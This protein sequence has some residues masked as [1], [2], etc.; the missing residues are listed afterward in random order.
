ML[1]LPLACDKPAPDQPKG[2]TVVQAPSKSNP[3]NPFLG[4]PDDQERL[5]EQEIPEHDPTFEPRLKGKVTLTKVT[6]VPYNQLMA[7]RQQGD[8]FSE[9]QR[10]D[11]VYFAIETQRPVLLPGADGAPPTPAQL[12]VVERFKAKMPGVK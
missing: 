10:E 8:V 4:V 9:E 12:R 5:Y 6:E 11:W 7:V 1:L 3:G 2:E